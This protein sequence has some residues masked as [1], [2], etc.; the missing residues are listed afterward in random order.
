MQIPEVVARK[1]LSKHLPSS[2]WKEQPDR[3]VCQGLP[4][5]SGKFLIIVMLQF[6]HLLNGSNRVVGNLA[7]RLTLPG[8]WTM[9]GGAQNVLSKGCL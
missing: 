6:A 2:G 8:A 4:N 9:L 3:A 1:L 5:S 7:K